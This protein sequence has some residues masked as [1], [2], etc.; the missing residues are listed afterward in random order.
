[1]IVFQDTQDL[2]YLQSIM[3]K[4][5]QKSRFIQQY[6]KPLLHSGLGRILKNI[7]S[8]GFGVLSIIQFLACLPLMGLYTIGGIFPS[9]YANFVLCKKDT[10]YRLKNNANIPWRKIMASITRRFLSLCAKHTTPQIQ[11]KKSSPS[12]FIFDDTDLSKTGEKIEGVSRI[13]S[14]VNHAYSL[15]F[16][17]LFFG[18][19]DGKSFLP[20]NFSLHREKGTKSDKPFGLTRKKIAQQF[21]KIRTENQAGYQ[22]KEELDKK[23]TDMVV[24]MMQ[25]AISQGIKADFALCDSW[26]FCFNLLHFVTQKGMTLVSGVKIGKINFEYNGKNYSPK[27]LLNIHKGKAKFCRKLKMHYIPLVVRYKGIEIRLFFVRYANQSK[28]RIIMNS[29]AKMPFIKTMEIYQIR[30]SIEVFFKEAKQYLGLAKC[31]SNDFDAHIAHISM[32]CVLFMALALKKR[33]DCQETI[34]GLFRHAKVEMNEKT[35]AHKMWLL[36][37]RIVQNLTDFF[38]F[39]PKELIKKLFDETLSKKFIRLFDNTPLLE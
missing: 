15:G 31:Q 20:T 22:R 16:K 8:K 13:W 27:S 19:W 23:K 17:G 38:D 32:V 25:Y 7:K 34:G 4:D 9:E 26:F 3:E 2:Q 14:H 33:V 29:D 28:W 6:L 35:L 1:M 36:F 11:D 10:F 21:S 37:C 24:E 39:E 18:L 12:C 30:W 5:A